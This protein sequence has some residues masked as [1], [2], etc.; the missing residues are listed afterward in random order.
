MPIKKIVFLIIIFIVLIILDRN[1]ETY[2]NFLFNTKHQGERDKSLGYFSVVDTDIEDAESYDIEKLGPTCVAKCVAEH[3]ANIQFNNPDGNIDAL[4]WNK[5]NPNKGYCYEQ[6]PNNIHLNV[7]K[8]V[9]KINVHLMKITQ[10]K[11]VVIMIRTK[12]F[13]NVWQR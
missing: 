12:I 4:K 9:S 2:I 7:M 6:I 3:G 8:I 10:L 1:K 11:V 13:H 5:E